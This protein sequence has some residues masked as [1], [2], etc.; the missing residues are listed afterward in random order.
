MSALYRFTLL[1]FWEPTVPPQPTIKEA[2]ELLSLMFDWMKGNRSGE[3]TKAIVTKVQR[4]FPDWDGSSLEA[5]FGRK[6]GHYHHTHGSN[7]KSGKAHKS[8]GGGQ[9][10]TQAEPQESQGQGSQE[11]SQGQQSEH[12]SPKSKS[13]EH[14]GQQQSLPLPDHDAPKSKGGNGQGSQ[15]Q[16]QGE[17]QQGQGDQGEGQGNSDGQQGDNDQG[18][19]QD[20]GET[21]EKQSDQGE[22]DKGQKAD[23]PKSKGKGKGKDSKGQPDKKRTPPKTGDATLDRLLLLFDAYN[24]NTRPHNY[25]LYGPSGTGKTTLCGMFADRVKMPCTVLSCSEGTAPSEFVGRRLPTPEPSA[26]SQAFGQPGV[27]VFDEMTM[28]DPSVAAVANAL[29]ANK[30]IQTSTGAVKRHPQCVIIATSNTIGDGADRSYIGNNQLDAATLNRFA[31]GRIY[32]DYSEK[33]E[34]D[35]YDREVCEYAWMLRKT[36]ARCGIRRIV[37]T[38]EIQAA[39]D[40]K[41]A[42]HDWWRDSMTETWTDSEKANIQN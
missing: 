18:Q 2:T 38:R 17:Q 4:W 41:L 13:P 25:W 34:R 40:L 20:Q 5:R 26:V 31:G 39:H 32:V 36:M 33:Y 19:Q 15:N 24:G 16:S 23:K 28:L 9:P 11:Q 37:S 21:E 42:G 7:G 29:L 14:H 10:S 6:H 22:Q 8:N 12:K 1:K 27:I 35:N 30:V 3:Q